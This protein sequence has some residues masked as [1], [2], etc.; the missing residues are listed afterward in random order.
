M[1]DN[2]YG[3]DF[4]NPSF[5]YKKHLYEIDSIPER[6]QCHAANIILG[7]QLNDE[8]KIYCAW[9]AGTREANLDVSIMF[10]EIN[11]RPDPNPNLI[12]FNYGIPRVIASHSDRACGNPVLFLDNNDTLHLWYPAFWPRESGKKFKDRNIYHKVSK[13]FGKTWSEPKTFSDR[14]GLWV[15]NPVLVLQNGTWLLPM[16]DEV[17]FNWKAW[18]FWS[19]R[20]AFSIDQGVSWAFSP[21]YSIWKGMIQPSVVQFPDGELYCLNRSRTGWL[22]EM[23]SKDNGKT[24]TKPR[25]TEIPN[26][27]ACAC[28]ILCRDGTLVMAYNPLKKGRNILSIAISKDQ[29]FHWLRMFDLEHESDG[30]FSYPCLLETPGGLIHVVYTYKRRTIEHAV[31]KI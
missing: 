9:F 19:S 6:P 4:K 29:G 11:Y 2:H 15:K 23:R 18:T 16:N 3:D 1:M 7:K 13:D 30:E 27:N 31:F 17:K 28:M 8:I 21:L 10:T 12:K 24:W 25:N 5:L 22:V 14:P 26:N 20:F